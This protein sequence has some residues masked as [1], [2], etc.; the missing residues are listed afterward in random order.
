LIAP[1][2]RWHLSRF[3]QDSEDGLIFVGPNGGLLRRGNFRQRVWVKALKHA[4]LPPMHFHDLRHTGNHLT[5]AAG[6][7]LRELMVR[8]GHS[9]TRAA[10]IYQHATDERQR[11]IADALNQLARDQL[12]RGQG[13]SRGG[14]SGTRRARKRREAS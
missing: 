3:A 10:M 13:R 12:K 14:R 9:S 4:G 5:A 8:M 7:N 1:V 6:A 11:E 2:V